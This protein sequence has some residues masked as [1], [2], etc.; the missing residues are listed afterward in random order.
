MAT[1]RFFCLIE[2]GV[3][4]IACSRNHVAWSN[5]ETYMREFM[6]LAKSYSEAKTAPLKVFTQSAMITFPE[7]SACS[8]Y[9]P[10]HRRDEFCH[11]LQRGFRLIAM[12]RVLAIGQHHDLRCRHPRLDR[13][14]LRD[15]A[16]LILFTL[17]A[18]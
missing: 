4:P 9:I 1:R 2:A 14:Q 7:R 17:N 6:W 16:V 12:R 3:T 15:R 18:Q 10:V 8:W 11:T 5:R 13:L